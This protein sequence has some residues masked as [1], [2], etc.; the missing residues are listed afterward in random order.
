M[1]RIKKWQSAVGAAVMA[2]VL[3]AG[4]AFAA[5]ST[6][7]GK[8]TETASPELQQ[9]LSEI[10]TLRQSRMESLQTEVG[11][12]IDKA[13]TDGKITQDQADQLKQRPM[14]FRKG[15]GQEG[16]QKFSGKRGGMQ[17]LTEEQVKAKLDEAVKSGKLTQEKADQMLKR[18]QECHTAQES[19]SQ[20]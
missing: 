2:A 15:H 9:V 12:L 1:I 11:Q 16:S 5:D 6:Q 13:V 17:N 14:G 19:E 7:A 10:R 8:S 3:T 4:V 18:W 20:S